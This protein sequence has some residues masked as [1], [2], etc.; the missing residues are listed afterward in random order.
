MTLSL[1]ARTGWPFTR[2]Q[3]PTLLLVPLETRFSPEPARLIVLGGGI[4]PALS[5]AHGTPVFDSAG[6]RRGLR[7]TAFRPGERWL[8]LYTGAMGL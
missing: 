4:D 1:A 2:G 5:A 3:A 8:L 6:A 7:V